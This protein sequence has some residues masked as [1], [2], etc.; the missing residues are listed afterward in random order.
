M[1]EQSAPGRYDICPF[2]KADK[3][4]R[5]RADTQEWVHDYVHGGPGMSHAFCLASD[6][7]KQDDLNG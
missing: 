5:F 3:P 7:R 2:C 6:L 4:I 1:T